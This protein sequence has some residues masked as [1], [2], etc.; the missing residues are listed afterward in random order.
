[1][2]HLPRW[3]FGY[4]AAFV[5]VG[6]VLSV[7]NGCACTPDQNGNSCVNWSQAGG[8]GGVFGGGW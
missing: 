3:Y 4:L 8:W 5:A 1:M 7:L 2:R 6:I